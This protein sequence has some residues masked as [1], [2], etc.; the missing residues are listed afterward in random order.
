M[1]ASS[2]PAL[3]RLMRPRSVAL[4]GASPDST[5]IGGA[6]LAL[7]GQFGW[8]GELHLVSRRH[9]E[10][11]GR[12]CVESVDDLPDG[13]DAA[14]LAVPRDAVATVLDACIRRRIGGVIA[15]ASGF[16][17][18]GP[19]GADAQRELAARARAGGVALAGPNCLGLV[20]FRD[21][22]PLTF[23]AVEPAPASPPVVGRSALAIVAQSGAMS[24]ALLYAAASDAIPLS[25]V[26]STG[27]EAAL[28]V[29]DYLEA[30]IADDATRAI[31]LLVEQIRQPERFL[32]AAAAARRA[33]VALCLL[34]TGTSERGRDAARTHTGALAGDQALL[35]A[36]LAREAVVLVD[37]LDALIDA[38][39]VLTRCPRPAA[40]GVGFLTDSGALKAHALDVC[41]R[42]GLEIPDPGPDA[43]RALRAVLPPFATASNPVDITGHA[44]NEPS[45]YAT[46][47]DALLEDPAIGA[48]VVAAMPGSPAQ[49]RQQV[50][51]LLPV[52]TGATK[53]I[54]YC[55]LG[56]QRPLPSDQL[57]RLRAAGVA[58]FRS[59]ERALAA[60]GHLLD[61]ARDRDDDELILAAPLAVP[62]TPQPTEHETKRLLARIGLRAPEG[63]LATTLA[64]AHRIAARLGYPVVIKAQA[65]ALTHKSDA[66]GVIVGIDGDAALS[67]AW[68]RLHADVGRA[69]PELVLDGVLVER[70][71]PAGVEVVVAG[72]RDPEWGA[73]VMVGLGGIW[74]EALRD[75]R[76]VAATA[77]AGEVRRELA[78]L[79]GYPLLAGGRGQPPADLD[80][81]V[82][83]IL[84]VAAALRA[85]PDI[86]ELEINPLLV[87]PAGG[88]VLALDAVLT[89][90][91]ATLGRSP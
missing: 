60:V 80:A 36:V 83:A 33:G 67:R 43:A 57:T 14:I 53:P 28:G 50:D 82:D 21:G 88:G 64:D 11:A 39:G 73:V 72:H 91:P 86:R 24:F 42:L 34:H 1:A 27:N 81:L 51:A 16:A 54:V 31:A 25:Y 77:G 26:I 85:S 5:A 23:G 71:A 63:A 37:S 62:A 29:E 45:L 65:G 52:I 66:G 10:I 46:A 20:N 76:V 47:A 41:D 44:L 55:V 18:I 8:R 87:L 59:P 56:G 90:D 58:L 13:V 19:E 15:F 61:H 4:V 74:I 68:V 49:F 48:L 12:P 30:L 69:R 17:E 78:A 6:P 35:R 2:R 9:R 7:L 75:V 40:H 84:R 79:R 89:R 22:I 70:M 3:E 38:G 32:A